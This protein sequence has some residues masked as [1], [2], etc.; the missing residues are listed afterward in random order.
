M[1][2]RA[3]AVIQ[4]Q[5]L[6]PI[7]PYGEEL[8]SKTMSRSPTIFHEILS[9]DLPVSEKHA[10]R[11]GEEGF[12]VIAAGGET[13]GRTL[14]VATYFIISNPRVLSNLT[15]ELRNAMPLPY[16]KPK[17]KELEQLP[18][19]VSQPLAMLVQRFQI[20]L[21]NKLFCNILRQNIQGAVIKES[22]RI[23]AL[24]TSRLPQISPHEPLQ[25]QDLTIPPGVSRNPVPTN[26]IR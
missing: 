17:L 14:T 10:K 12:V 25:F 8:K 24:V 18:W 15:L 11:L 19:L 7:E 3:A 20:T 5:S 23:S 2:R 26:N 21:S 16:D 22:I 4:E 13:T 1:R 6:N 9:S